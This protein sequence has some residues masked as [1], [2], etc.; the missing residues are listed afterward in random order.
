MTRTGQ[1]RKASNDL[2]HMTLDSLRKQ[3]KDTKL[4]TTA[5]KLEGPD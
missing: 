5:K 4:A 3:L 1:N 2:L